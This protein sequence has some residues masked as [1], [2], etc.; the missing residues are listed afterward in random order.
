M[1]YYIEDFSKNKMIWFFTGFVVGVYTAQEH[2]LPNVKTA[3]TQLVYFIV[4]MYEK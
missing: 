1:F 2:K 4:E 3:A